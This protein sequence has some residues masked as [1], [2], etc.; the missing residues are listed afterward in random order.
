MID[1][2]H[3]VAMVA[4]AVTALFATVGTVWFAM[5][6]AVSIS[7]IGGIVTVITSL[8]AAYFAY[9]AKVISEEAKTISEET[10]AVSQ[11]TGKAVNGKM[12]QMLSIGKS[13]AH[14]EGKAEGKTEEKLKAA[15]II[16][17]K[18][19]GK[20]EAIKYKVDESVNKVK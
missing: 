11:E 14:A 13:L 20:T 4:N 10:K 5:S 19:D 9:R 18:E 7:I 12:E 6:D 1:N 3:P 16:L 2:H 15:V 17:A 8:A